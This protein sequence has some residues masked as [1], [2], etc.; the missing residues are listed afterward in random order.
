MNFEFMPELSWRYGYYVIL[1]IMA[2]ICGTLYWRFHRN[3]WL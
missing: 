3:G 2:F 1:S